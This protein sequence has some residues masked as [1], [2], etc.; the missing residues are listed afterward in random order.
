M[1]MLIKDLDVRVITREG[2]LLR[3]LTLD[4]STLYHGTG[5]P[6]GPPKGRPLGPRKKKA[7][8]MS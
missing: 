2:E 6:P 1:L 3:Q 7:S 4:P 5:A 8:T